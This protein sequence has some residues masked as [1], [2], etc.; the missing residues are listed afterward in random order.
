MIEW[1]PT[2][3]LTCL[4]VEPEVDRDGLYYRYIVQRGGLMLE[5]GIDQFSYDVDLAISRPEQGSIVNLLMRG[6]RAIRYVRTGEGEQLVFISHE[7]RHYRPNLPSG[8]CLRITPSL[9]LTIGDSQPL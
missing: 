9:H 3:V 7:D 2:D 6:C 4:E 5:L 1:N 8:M